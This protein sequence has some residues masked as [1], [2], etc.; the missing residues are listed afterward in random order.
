M[1]HWVGQKGLISSKLNNG[2]INS[3]E[4]LSV[5]GP[6]RRVTL[7]VLC[8]CNIDALLL[9]CQSVNPVEMASRLQWPY[10]PCSTFSTQCLGPLIDTRAWHCVHLVP[11]QTLILSSTDER[12][13]TLDG[14]QQP[15]IIILFPI[16]LLVWIKHLDRATTLYPK[17]PPCNV[18]LQPARS[19]LTLMEVPI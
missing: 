18:N 6:T 7:C 9:Y 16:P 12:D 17:Q 14:Q 1:R 3:V 19:R 13:I 8:T 15:A 2:E 5:Y 10:S 4:L 11:E